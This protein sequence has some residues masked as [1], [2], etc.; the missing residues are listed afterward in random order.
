MWQ[1][2][3]ERWRR[4]AD[5]TWVPTGH[6]DSPRRIVEEGSGYSSA[7]TL[8]TSERW[9]GGDVDHHTFEMRWFQDDMWHHHRQLLEARL[10]LMA[11]SSGGN[12]WLQMARARA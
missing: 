9:L 7:M 5:E 10:P 3:E 1:A 8:D 4:T 2:V 6:F 12:I 11:K